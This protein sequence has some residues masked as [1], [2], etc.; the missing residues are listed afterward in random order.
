MGAQSACDFVGR[1]RACW[2]VRPRRGLVTF[3]VRPCRLFG[4]GR[5]ENIHILYGFL[6]VCSAPHPFCLLQVRT[7][8]WN[9]FLHLEEPSLA[10][11]AV[12]VMSSGPFSLIKRRR[13][14]L[15]VFS[16]WSRSL[17]HFIFKTFSVC[18]SD[19]RLPWAPS[20]SS[21]ALPPATVHLPLTPSSERCCVTGIKLLNPRI[22]ICF[23]HSFCLF[24]VTSHL[25]IFKDHDFLSTL[26][27]SSMSRF[28][29]F[30]AISITCAS[31]GQV[32]AHCVPPFIVTE[33]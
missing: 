25:L 20:S 22:P 24:A 16:H 1:G 3:P 21:P 17:F 5:E 29:V 19:S 15:L 33:T 18:S 26:R 4:N 2:Q 14:D 8:I 10:F 9:Q 31:S 6:H 23:S 13:L 28:N 12:R 27:Y 32:P 11:R 7:S 30:G